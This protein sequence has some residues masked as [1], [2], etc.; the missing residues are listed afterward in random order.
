MEL[1]TCVTTELTASIKTKDEIFL[2]EDWSAEP[3]SQQM[4]GSSM[5]VDKNYK[6][7]SACLTDVGMVE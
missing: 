6:L 1:S 5:A 4:P 3:C 2:L 7:S